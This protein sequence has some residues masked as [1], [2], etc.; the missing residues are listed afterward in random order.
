MVAVSISLVAVELANEIFGSLQN[1]NILIVG[2]G[3][4]AKLTAECLMKRAVGK[5]KIT[6]RTRENAEELLTNL[7]KS[8]RF[9]SEIVDFADFKNHLNETDIVISSTSAPEPILSF[10]DFV[11]QTN[12]ILLIDLAVP[13]DIAPEV[14]ALKNVVLKN[15][16]DLHQIIDR[17]YQRRMA[18]LPLVKRN[19][20]REMSDFLVWYYSLPLLPNA[21]R[22]G[23]KPDAATLKE[24]VGVKEFL[25]KNVSQVHKLAMRNGAENFAGHV[26]VVNELAAMKRAAVAHEKR[27]EIEA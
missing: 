14:G 25:L 18:D 19:I 3:E 7:Q 22:G 1:K 20:M 21:L 5:I 11:N 27:L 16:D 24:I 15:V 23:V 13:R 4:T 26:A 2:A 6:N 9:E 10:A 12:K 8:N 17:N